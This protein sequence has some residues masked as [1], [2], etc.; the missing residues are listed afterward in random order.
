MHPINFLVFLIYI[1]IS[2]VSM[3]IL[4]DNYFKNNNKEK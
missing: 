3:I 1:I 2:G 4:T